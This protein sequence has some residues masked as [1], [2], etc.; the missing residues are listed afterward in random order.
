MRIKLSPKRKEEIANALSGY[1]QE[2]FD[3]EL[4]EYR[5]MTLVEF[6]LQKIGPS[7]YNQAVT[8]VRKFLT[9]KVEEL[10]TE[11]YEP[12]NL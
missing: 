12:E 10:D 4:S 8:D 2:Q 7:Q 11:F 1:Y 3:E 9:E 6:L 5:A